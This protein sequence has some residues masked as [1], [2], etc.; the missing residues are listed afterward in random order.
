MQD[1][2]SGIGQKIKM[3]CL[4]QDH[5]SVIGQKIKLL[6]LQQGKTQQDLAQFLGYTSSGMMSQVEHGQTALSQEKLSRLADYLG[7]PSYVLLN[8]RPYSDRDLLLFAQLEVVLRN[9]PESKHLSTIE[10]LLNLAATE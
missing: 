5:K 3:M 10:S 8:D 7:V 9:N 1:H 4:Q 6:R 2:K